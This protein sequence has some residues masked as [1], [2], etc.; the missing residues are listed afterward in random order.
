MNQSRTIVSL[1][2]GPAMLLAAG[3]RMHDTNR[4]LVERELRLQ[5]DEIYRLHDELSEHEARFSQLK[6]ENETLKRELAQARSPAGSPPA[7]RVDLP[8]A[9]TTSPPPRRQ[10]GSVVAPPA[11]ASPPSDSAPPGD[12]MPPQ[13]ELP[14]VDSPQPPAPGPENGSSDR[15]TRGASEVRL[16]SASVDVGAFEGDVA[17]I[18]LNRRLTGGFNADG[19]LGDEGVLVVVEPRDAAERLVREPGE[20]SLAVIDPKLR[21]D[22][23]RVGRWSFTADESLD[24][25]KKTEFGDGYHFELRWPG[26][27]PQHERLMLFVRFT[28]ER[29]KRFEAQQQIVVDVGRDAVPA[30]P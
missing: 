4:E 15:R 28:D 25:F 22:E 27:P 30:K 16:A 8:P 1:L 23:A 20:V 26:E 24:H 5:E 29:G 11:D 3:C 12:L 7:P 21:S 19:T 18:V 6:R 14:G 9:P 13:V 10:P 2:L 17:K